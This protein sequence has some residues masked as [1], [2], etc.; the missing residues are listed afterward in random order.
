MTRGQCPP[1]TGKNLEPG[2]AKRI[3]LLKDRAQ[4]RTDECDQENGVDGE[5]DRDAN[6]PC[7][8]LTL[9]N[10]L[11]ED[12][13]RNDRYCEN[14]RQIHRVN[15][16]KFGAKVAAERGRS[17]EESRA[18]YLH[19]YLRPF[20]SS[21]HLYLQMSSLIRNVIRNSRSEYSTGV[22][23]TPLNRPTPFFRHDPDFR[24]GQ[25]HWFFR[26]LK[27]LG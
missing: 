20:S 3:L 14:K 7:D 18:S 1:A 6:E 22:I 16:K 10:E 19:S 25:Q 8:T 15:G 5:E 17:S 27:D 24:G 26:R 9:W 13:V 12:S 4:W 21:I 11:Q 2:P 23:W